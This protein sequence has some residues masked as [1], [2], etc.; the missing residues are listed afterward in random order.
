MSKIWG[1]P[2]AEINVAL[3]DGS[4]T[5]RS[6]VETAQQRY[7]EVGEQ[8][9]MY[10]SRDPARQLRE[11]AAADAAFAAGA[12]LGPLQGIP[13]SA[14][15][16]YGVPGY[17]TFAGSPKQLPP[18]W[19]RAG[20]VVRA[21]QRQLGVI[22]GKTHTVEFAFGGLGSNP[23][24][25][26]PRNPWDAK[27]HRAPGGS[28]AGA[29][30]S[31]HCDAMLALG[32]DT[33]GSVR[34]PASMTGTVGLKTSHGRWSREGIVPLSPSL[35][36]P[37]I[38]ARDV[39]DVRLGFSQLDNYTFVDTE[40]PSPSRLTIGICEDFFWSDCDPGVDE[41]VRGALAELERAGAR[42]Q[43]IDLVE[44]QPAFELFK[45]GHLA[46][47]EF[48]EFLVNEL[49]DWMDTLDPRVKARM[50]D[51]AALTAVEYIQRRRTL[52]ELSD[53][54]DTRLA[55]VDVL[56]S[57]TIPNTPPI[58]S[59]VVELDDYRRA[60]MLALR[61]TC[62]GNL[63][64][65]CGITMPVALDS[66]GMPVGLQLLARGGNDVRLLNIASAVEKVLG[67]A[68]ERLGKPPTEQAL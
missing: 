61:N 44:T 65:L 29:G 12:D 11:A 55:G 67:T 2:L 9:G 45:I 5:A 13:I 62:M 57:P 59:E 30:V 28:S 10:K 24:W 35:D 48:Y 8:L 60:N 31:L 19:E 46:A 43:T 32:T 66:A 39:A 34:I 17:P 26:V 21:L 36:T 16:L 6:L 64:S 38:L 41:G 47:P 51:A 18:N 42:L 52:K 54:A 15:D 1:R 14:K 50:P 3:R 23:H 20:P 40:I 49:P 37:G 53:S 25:P 58:L 4:A 33:A 22:M 56:A 27:Q 7:A 68:G 63:L